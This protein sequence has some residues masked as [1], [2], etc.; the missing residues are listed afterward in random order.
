M[1]AV[2]AA[3]ALAAVDLVYA[4]RGSISR[5]Y[6][7]DAAVELGLAAG[8]IASSF[9]RFQRRSRPPEIVSG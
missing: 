2:G 3:G 7:A 6:L 8:W 1:M 9:R 4:G 5:V